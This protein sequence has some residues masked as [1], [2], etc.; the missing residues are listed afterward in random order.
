MKNK[1][2]MSLDEAFNLMG[3]IKIAEAN[4]KTPVGAAKSLSRHLGKGASALIGPCLPD[5]RFA[6]YVATDH[7]HRN[8]NIPEE[9]CEFPVVITTR[10][11]DKDYEKRNKKG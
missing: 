9:W 2:G 3:L 8:I 6:L 4:E 10:Q 7:E 1:E 5:G 11:Y